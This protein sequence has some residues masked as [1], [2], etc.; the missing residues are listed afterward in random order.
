[1]KSGKYVI[2]LIL[3]FGFISGQHKNVNAEKKSLVYLKTDLS[4]KK[5]KLLKVDLHTKPV[6][7]KEINYLG[8]TTVTLLGA[9]AFITARTY[10]ENSWW[11]D[12]RGSFRFHNDWDYA[13]GADKFGHFFGGYAITQI[14]TSAFDAANFE[15]DQIYLYSA[16]FT[17]AFQTYIEIEDGFSP[18]WGFSPGDAIANVLGASYRY[19]QYRI[20]YL[21]NIKP[22]I[23]YYPSDEFRDGKIKGDNI[24]DDYSGQKFWLSFK[25]SKIIPNFADYWPEWLML[26][27]GHG[28]RDY[29][30]D[31]IHREF[32]LALDIDIDE[33]PLYGR[34]WNFIK[35]TLN[36]FHV[37][38]P[39]IR[40]TPEGTFFEIIF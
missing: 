24:T 16:L 14:F 27:A 21:N 10:F 8:L 4:V 30:S 38:M 5:D 36:L 13:L 22:K 17:I 28:I 37:P 9:G 3:T 35:S 33:L 11:S 18:E 32:Y 1:M 40:V 23:S 15:Q 7:K 20:P 2:I 25:L 34:F 26:A 29:K 31:N 12:E 19:M 6:L 39:G